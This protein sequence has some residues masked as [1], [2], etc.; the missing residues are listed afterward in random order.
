MPKMFMTTIASGA[1]R[2]VDSFRKTASAF[3]RIR[4]KT[5]L[6]LNM[7]MCLCRGVC[8]SKGSLSSCTI[9]NSYLHGPTS[10]VEEVFFNGTW[11]FAFSTLCDQGRNV[12]APASKRAERAGFKAIAAYRRYSQGLAVGKLN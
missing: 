12:D 1:E 3:S 2:P 8:N 11:N 4:I 7:V 9:M 10:S 6:F 5:Y